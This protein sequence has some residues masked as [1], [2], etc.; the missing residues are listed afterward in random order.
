LVIT[1]CDNQPD[2]RGEL[3]LDDGRILTPNDFFPLNKMTFRLYYTSQCADQQTID[4]YIEDNAG[5][6]IQKSFS[7]SNENENE[8]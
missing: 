6:V 1:T 5:Q 7:F 2:G 3:R 4:I 8:E